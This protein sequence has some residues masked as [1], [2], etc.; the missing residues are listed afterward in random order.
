[1]DIRG[2][3]QLPDVFFNPVNH[4]QFR[5]GFQDQLQPFHLLDG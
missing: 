3:Q 1:M 5:I 4:T 2:I